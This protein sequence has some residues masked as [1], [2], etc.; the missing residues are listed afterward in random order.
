MAIFYGYGHVWTLAH[1][2]L[3]STGERIAL[4]MVNS[5]L[6]FTWAE[7]WL[8]LRSPTSYYLG[9]WQQLARRLEANTTTHDVDIGGF[10]HRT[11][12]A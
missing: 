11:Y 6:I 9:K 10:T 4:R 7:S 3:Q 2:R 8:P 1:R 12:H 5:S